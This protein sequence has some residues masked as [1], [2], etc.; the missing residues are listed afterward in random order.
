MGCLALSFIKKFI[1]G[2]ERKT[3]HVVTGFVVLVCSWG[4][5]G[6]ARTAYIEKDP[7]FV[8]LTSISSQIASNGH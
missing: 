2:F 6:W 3:A 8:S 1:G 7:Q 5:S 4:P